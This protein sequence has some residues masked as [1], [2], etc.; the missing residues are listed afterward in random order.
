MSVT[1][2]L[3]SAKGYQVLW[4]VSNNNHEAFYGNPSSEALK[5]LM[6]DRNSASGQASDV[7]WDGDVTL[8]ADLTPLNAA[9]Q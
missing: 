6:E 1:I 2:P 8:L 5:Q 9:D 3:L 7:L 4:D